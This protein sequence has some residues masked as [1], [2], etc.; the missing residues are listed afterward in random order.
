[1]IALRTLVTALG[2]SA[3]PR[4]ATL[5]ADGRGADFRR[6]LLKLMGIGAVGGVL[7]VLAVALAGK[8]IILL[9]YKPE[10]AS[11][12]DAFTWIAVACA[13]TFVVSFTGYGMTALRI[14]KI[15]PLLTAG[16][17]VIT[18]GLC[19]WLVPAHGLTGAAWATLI[20]ASIQLLVNSTIVWTGSHRQARE[21][22]DG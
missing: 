5:Y 11:H 9:L 18:A 16:A 13:V 3:A 10:F 14:F 4:L 20:V 19:F 22:T 12:L 15:Q 8:F 1:M 6:L 7:L 17:V 2:Q 21:A